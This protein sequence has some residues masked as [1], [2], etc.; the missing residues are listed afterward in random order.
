LY[1]RDHWPAHGAGLADAIIAVST[2]SVGAALVTFNARHYPM[3]DNI[4]VPYRRD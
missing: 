4:V 1:R 3:V 2:K